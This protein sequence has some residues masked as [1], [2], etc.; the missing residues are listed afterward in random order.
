MRRIVTQP[1]RDMII[2]GSGSIVSQLTQHGLGFRPAP[3]GGTA[4]R[5]WFF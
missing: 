5:S 4:W 1:G 3:A 2:L